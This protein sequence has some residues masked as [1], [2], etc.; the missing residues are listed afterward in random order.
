MAQ[1]SFSAVTRGICACL[2][3]AEWTCHAYSLLPINYT[4][5]H[6]G[7]GRCLCRESDFVNPRGGG[8]ITLLWNRKMLCHFFCV[9]LPTSIPKPLTF[10]QHYREWSK[11]KVRSKALL[12]LT[13]VSW[14][15]DLGQVQR[16]NGRWIEEW[17]CY[18]SCTKL[19][20]CDSE[21]RAG[22]SEAACQRLFFEALPLEITTSCD[23]RCSMC[24]ATRS[25]NST[26]AAVQIRWKREELKQ[27]QQT[28]FSF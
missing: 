5:A 27:T 23:G 4:A 21:G 11:Q 13:P 7:T 12:L 6:E 15:E 10:L 8:K 17:L 20:C 3:Y 18:N 25:L 16:N 2:P 9:F 19:W 22:S 24:C 14:A 28:Q 26:Q 1:N